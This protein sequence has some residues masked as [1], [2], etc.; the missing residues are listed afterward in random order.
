VF[1]RVKRVDEFHLFLKR[2]EKKRKKEKGLNSINK[3][4]FIFI[5]LLRAQ[6]N[7]F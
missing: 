4:D 1:Y 7:E 5:S 3:F 6:K 2:K